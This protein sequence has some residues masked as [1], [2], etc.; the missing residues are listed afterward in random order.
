MKAKV[1]YSVQAERDLEDITL[2]TLGLWGSKQA[3]IYT[4]R[5]QSCCELIAQSPNLGRRCESIR[6]GLHRHEV[7]RHVIF[8]RI[9]VDHVV[10]T[11]ILH[12]RMKIKLHSLG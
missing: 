7:G 6:P 4:D 3:A 9:G 8:Y 12:G 11:R 1:V 10:V 5:L 2:Y